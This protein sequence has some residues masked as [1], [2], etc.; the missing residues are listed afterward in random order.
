MDVNM[1]GMDGNE[2]TQQL[3]HFYLTQGGLQL[4]DQPIVAAVTGQADEETLRSCFQSGMNMVLSKPVEIES[5]VFVCSQAD[6]TSSEEIARLE[7]E[8]KR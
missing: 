5:L 6:F 4:R 1:P 8:R 3:R 2:V 7:Q